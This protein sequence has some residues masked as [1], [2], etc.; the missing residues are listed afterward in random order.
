MS[1]EKGEP[2]ILDSDL[3][4]LDDVISEVEAPANK[5]EEIIKD[6]IEALRK[7]KGTA[8]E[9][10][11]KFALEIIK[12]Y[13]PAML[14]SEKQ[15]ALQEIYHLVANKFRELS[16]IMRAEREKVRVKQLSR[17][18]AL[19]NIK[20]AIENLKHDAENIVQSFQSGE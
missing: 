1:K 13:H 4:F 17:H 9:S 14:S 3:D 7:K 2:T 6:Y 8:N 11:R 10:A 16:S 18:T 19:G 20:S 12:V 15:V 5:Q